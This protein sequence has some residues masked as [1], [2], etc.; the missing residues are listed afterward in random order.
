L[1]GA[2]F[3]YDA[4][5]EMMM[6]SFARLGNS[7]KIII[8]RIQEGIEIKERKALECKRKS[9]GVKVDRDN[10]SKFISMLKLCSCERK[11]TYGGLIEMS[12]Q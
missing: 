2:I 12:T 6:R 11:R 8:K 3:S 4:I 7:D 10:D 5:K 9:K 1:I